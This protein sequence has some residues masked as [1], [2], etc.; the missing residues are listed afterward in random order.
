MMTSG[1][2]GRDRT[3]RSQAMSESL[4]GEQAG[5]EDRQ[6]MSPVATAVVNIAAMTST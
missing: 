4:A 1:A 3:K 6:R 2:H 5:A